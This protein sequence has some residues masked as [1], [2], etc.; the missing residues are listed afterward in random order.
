MKE[1]EDDKLIDYIPEP[2]RQTI[3]DLDASLL[4]IKDVLGKN[5]V[6][7]DML[8]VD[9]ATKDDIVLVQKTIEMLRQHLSTL[10]GLTATLFGLYFKEKSN[11]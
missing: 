1:I 8:S 2:H 5:M 7:N 9:T 11:Q 3:L 10:N 6:M 4:R